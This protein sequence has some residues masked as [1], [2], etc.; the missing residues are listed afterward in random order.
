MSLAGSLICF[1]ALFVWIIT[2]QLSWRHWEGAKSYMIYV[3]EE[4]RNDW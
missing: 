4:D 3:P 1:T 2:F